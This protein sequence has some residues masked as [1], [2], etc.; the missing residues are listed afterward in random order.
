MA[1]KT[2]WQ[3]KKCREERW[4]QKQPQQWWCLMKRFRWAA[5]V[6]C[7]AVLCN[8][9]TLTVYQLDLSHGS[10]WLPWKQWKKHH[11]ISRAEQATQALCVEQMTIQR[12]LSW[13]ETENKEKHNRF[14]LSVRK[15]LEPSLQFDLFCTK[16]SA[17][18]I[19]FQ[20]N[21]VHALQR[22]ISC[23]LADWSEPILYK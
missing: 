13:A 1:L 2:S 14:P 21:N 5:Q 6:D 9:K 20:F 17:Q 11:Y 10:A 19:W 8:G 4:K 23:T 18:I 22:S 12:N 7:F 3:N 16:W 15:K